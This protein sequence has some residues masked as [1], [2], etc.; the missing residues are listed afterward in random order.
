VEEEFIGA[1]RGE[2]AVRLTDFR[3]G[4]RYMQFTEA[5]SHSAQCG[6]VVELERAAD[7]G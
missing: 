3:S 5:V 2:E 7:T 6:V 4:L 1:I